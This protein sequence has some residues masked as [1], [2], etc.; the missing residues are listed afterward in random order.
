MNSKPVSRP[1]MPYY[2]EFAAALLAYGVLLAVSLLSLKSLSHDSGW[3]IPIALLP[4]LPAAGVVVA[5]V[6]QLG[7]VDELQRQQLLESLAIAFA[8][9]ALVTFG[10]GFLENV[11]FPLICWFLFFNLIAGFCR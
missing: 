2:T 11:G 9:T 1:W 6:R 5:V 7:R 4:M 8:G 10:Y 3:R